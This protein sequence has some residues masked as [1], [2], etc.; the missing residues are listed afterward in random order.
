VRNI[1]AKRF[2][3]PTVLLTVGPTRAYLDRVRYVS[4]F[5]S[6]ELGYYLSKYLVSN[7]IEV[8]VVAGP[9]IQPFKNLKLKKLID[10]ETA[11]QMYRETLKAC[12]LFEPQ[13][14]IFAAAVLDFKPTQ[15]FKGKMSSTNKQWNI[16]MVP[17]PK[18]I[19]AVEKRFPKIKRFGFKLEWD[20]RK[21]RELDDFAQQLINERN[22]E[23][24]CINF[25]PQITKTQHPMWFFSKEGVK[26]FT[27]T[28]KQ[29]AKSLADFVKQQVFQ[30]LG[31]KA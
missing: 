29:S 17:N 14:A 5:S 9:T 30:E 27:R 11:D 10:V 6:G 1:L 15:T 19:D 13:V 7:D 25:L 16:Q 18:I 22:L 24:V 31:L 12:R 4:N 23:G 8:I 26:K 20:I 21:E 2:R 3:K 28:K